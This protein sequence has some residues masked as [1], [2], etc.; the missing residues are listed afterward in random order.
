MDVLDLNVLG[1]GPPAGPEV[2]LS[3]EHCGRAFVFGSLVSMVAYHLKR[4]VC[5]LCVFKEVLYA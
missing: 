5:S 1:E 2:N 3:K 4:S